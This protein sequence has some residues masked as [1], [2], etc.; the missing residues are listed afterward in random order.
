[1]KDVLTKL[2]KKTNINMGDS[3]LRTKDGTVN[4]H[5]FRSTQWTAFLEQVYIHP[6]RCGPPNFFYHTLSKI[7]R[8]R[9]C[10]EYKIQ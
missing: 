6:F 2:G 8:R 10:L 4:L 3:K 1:M 5:P 9:V 7:K